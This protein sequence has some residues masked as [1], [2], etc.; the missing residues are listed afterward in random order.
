MFSLHSV[1]QD[2]ISVGVDGPGGHDDVLF[3][4]LL[5][6]AFQFVC[7]YC[8]QDTVLA[9]LVKIG[10]KHLF[11][12]LIAFYEVVLASNVGHDCSLLSAHEVRRA[13][14]MMHFLVF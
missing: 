9:C 14:R 2:Y 6:Q 4:K 1:F 3:V 13:R 11:S 8:G 7:F 12:L 10:E 5:Q